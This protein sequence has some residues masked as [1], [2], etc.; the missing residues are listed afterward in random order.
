MCRGGQTR[1]GICAGSPQHYGDI[2][3]VYEM[4]KDGTLGEFIGYFEV[5]DTG[6]E[7][8]KKGRKIDLWYEKEKYCFKFGY[9]TVLVKY[10]EG[11]G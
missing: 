2:A 9:K 8:I 10:I 7:S 4:N 3:C 6:G 1:P 5:L 11:K